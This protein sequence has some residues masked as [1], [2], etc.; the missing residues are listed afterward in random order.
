MAAFARQGYPGTPLPSRMLPGL[1]SIGYWD[2]ATDQTWGS[3]W[4]SIESLVVGYVSRGRMDCRIGIHTSALKSGQLFIVP[5]GQPHYLGAPCISAS[6]LHWLVLD[7]GIRPQP[8]S[9]HWPSWVILSKKELEHLA[10]LLLRNAAPF[11]PANLVLRSCFEQMVAWIP[12]LTALEAETRI[13][14]WVNNLLLELLRLL[15]CG[16]RPPTQNGSSIRSAVESFLGSLPD[17]VAQPWSVES[18]A[19]HCGLGRSRF[20]YYCEE[21]TNLSP[22]KYLNRCR[23]EKAARLLLNDPHRSITAIAFESGFQSSQYFTTTFHHAF[24]CVPSDYRRGCP[25]C[26]PEPAQPENCISQNCAPSEKVI[27]LSPSPTT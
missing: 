25:S 2:A 4:T 12:Q 5:P 18:M 8:A 22:L 20:A 13:K 3:G 11:Q 21:L 26:Q 24:G 7:L 17:R 19:S 10:L 6:R 23:L 15:K 14:L 9:Y 16:H 1:Q 27:L